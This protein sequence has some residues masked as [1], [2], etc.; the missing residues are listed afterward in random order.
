MKYSPEPLSPLDSAF[1]SLSHL[2]TP[3]SLRI[4]TGPHTDP[5]NP[6]SKSFVCRFYAKCA[7]KS[8]RIRSYE[9]HRGVGASPRISSLAF[10]I[11][12]LSPESPRRTHG[13]PVL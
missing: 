6:C 8:F 9:K 1:T 10:G 13:R 4:F 11:I 3:K 7:G 5:Q 12:P 2:S